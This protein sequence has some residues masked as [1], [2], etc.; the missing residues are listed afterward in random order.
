MR[1]IFLDIDGVLNGW[2]DTYDLISDILSSNRFTRKLW[3]NYDIFGVSFYRVFLLWIL[4]RLT[5]S[6]VVLSS[7]WRFGWY[8]PYK[9]CNKRMKSLKRKLSFF[10]I[11]VIGCT[12]NKDG[13]RGLEI[14]DWL[15]NTNYDVKSFV[16]L[17]DEDFDIKEFFPNH[18]VKTS[19]L[20][21]D[22]VMSGNR[23]NECSGLSLKYVFAAKKILTDKTIQSLAF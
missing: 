2:N 9:N 18:L 11:Q 1:V 22:D 15:D 21:T 7:S 23:E 3:E 20:S 6:K 19:N 4:V 14:K 5:N 17:D 10:H 12:N 8:I 13:M 16:I